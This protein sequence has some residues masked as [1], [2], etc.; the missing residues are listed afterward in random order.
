MVKIKMKKE[1]LNTFCAANNF[2][3][4]IVLPLIDFQAAYL[5]VAMKLQQHNSKC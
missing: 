4:P 5:E 3:H 2:V 1:K